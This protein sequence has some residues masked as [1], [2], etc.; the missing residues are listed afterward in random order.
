M[1]GLTQQRQ[2]DLWGFSL[3][4]TV[5]PFSGNY[6]FGTPNAVAGTSPGKSAIQQGFDVAKTGHSILTAPDKLTSAANFIGDTEALGFTG[7]IGN[8]GGASVAE[9]GSII[10]AAIPSVGG[11]AGIAGS[12]AALE[13]AGAAIP[14]IGVA[15][16]A[17]GAGALSAASIVP[18]LAFAAAAF[19]A[20]NA[21]TGTSSDISQFA[22]KR[23]GETTF[24]SKNVSTQFAQDLSQKFDTYLNNVENTLGVDL[25]GTNFFGGSHSKFGASVRTDFHGGVDEQQFFFDP[26]DAQSTADAFSDLTI[27][28]L[29]SKEG[30]EE[31]LASLAQ[32]RGEGESEGKAL[33]NMF[34][35]SAPSN[36]NEETQANEQIQKTTPRTA[37]GE[38]TVTRAGTSFEDFVSRFRTT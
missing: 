13:A 16:G 27:E 1:T 11:A 34:N 15:G 30:N 10:G 18:P 36:P 12:A 21:F 32:H 14:S 17:A 24:G 26:N 5:T 9:A 20:F 7:A 38:L 3:S 35:Q 33:Q 37:S 23:G 6:G 22:T 2:Q 8:V 25:S 4:N 28:L 29:K 19:F 31:F